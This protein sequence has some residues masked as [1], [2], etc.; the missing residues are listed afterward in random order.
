MTPGWTPSRPA[1]ANPMTMSQAGLEVAYVDVV[2]GVGTVADVKT[3]AGVVVTG[4][5][6]GEVEVGGACFCDGVGGGDGA[7]AVDATVGGFD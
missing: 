3:V 1:I 2:L 4:V 7:D 5:V 6:A